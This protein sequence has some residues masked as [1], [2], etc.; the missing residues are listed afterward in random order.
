MNGFNL[1][2]AVTNKINARSPRNKKLCSRPDL[3]FHNIIQHH[4]L[5]RKFHPSN[6]SNMFSGV[7]GV[8]S[9]APLEAR[10]KMEGSRQLGSPRVIIATKLCQNGGSL[11]QGSLFEGLHHLLIKRQPATAD[12]LLPP[13]QKPHRLNDQGFEQFIVGFIYI[14]ITTWRLL[15]HNIRAPPFLLHPLHSSSKIAPPTLNIQKYPVINQL[16]RTLPYYLQR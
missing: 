7:K 11:R 8:S 1:E 16:N 12:R 15:G 4:L 6:I 9:P 2:A 5:Y 10:T 13:Q 14:F 3:K